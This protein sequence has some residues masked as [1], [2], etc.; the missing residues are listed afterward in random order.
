M[1]FQEGDILLLRGQTRLGKLI[2]WFQSFWDNRDGASTC[3]H[4]AIISPGG[5]FEAEWPRTGVSPLSKYDGSL[6]EI[7]RCARIKEVGFAPNFWKL[8]SEQAGWIFPVWRWAFFAVNL[9]RYVHWKAGVC[10]EVVTRFLYLYDLVGGWWGWDVDML[11][12][13]FH[14]S[15]EW[16]MVYAG[17][18][19]D[20]NAV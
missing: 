9:A 3:T 15:P 10:S 19:R 2:N 6:I 12:D 20:R 11:A 7:W 5:V 14:T 4:A 18:G 16:T 17:K 8:Y 1:E 13:H